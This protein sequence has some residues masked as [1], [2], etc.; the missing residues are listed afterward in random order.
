M[1]TEIFDEPA[2]WELARDGDAE[3]FAQFFDAHHGRVFGQALRLIRNAHDAEE[4][5]AVVFLEAWRRRAAVRIVNGSII[6][7][8]LVTTN[9]VS[10]NLRRSRHRYRAAIDRL[11]HSV[12]EEGPFAELDERL[13]RVGRDA[14]VRSIFSQLTRNDQNVMTLCVIEELSLADAAAALGVPLGTVKSRLSRAKQRLARLTA[15]A[16][17]ENTTTSG[18]VK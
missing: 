3:A 2:A 17:D 4:V 8:L 12:A 9:N 13:D 14:T 1:G 5:T 10:H 18:G 11:S 6:G 15:E 16:F 7:W